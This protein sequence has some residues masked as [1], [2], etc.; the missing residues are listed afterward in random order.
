M[1]VA[2]SFV[3]MTDAFQEMW[4]EVRVTSEAHPI[5]VV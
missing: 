4:V 5:M 1:P 3:G 2:G